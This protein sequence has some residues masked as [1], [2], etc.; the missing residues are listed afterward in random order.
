MSEKHEAFS[1]EEIVETMCWSFFATADA[2]KWTNG[3]RLK[4]ACMMVATV[5]ST[6]PPDRRAPMIGEAVTILVTALDA[7]R[8]AER[9]T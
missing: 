5:I 8:D 7:C 4:A 1:F 6:A 9:G 2:N 3:D